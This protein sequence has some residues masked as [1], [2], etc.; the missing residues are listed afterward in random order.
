MITIL[1]G[2]RFE[3]TGLGL[4]GGDVGAAEG[5]KS[6]RKD[7]RS[8]KAIL[9]GLVGWRTTVVD[10]DYFRMRKRL[11]ESSVHR[12]NWLQLVR[13]GVVAQRMAGVLRRP[14]LRV[15]NTQVQE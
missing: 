2:F 3:D 10:D 13:G 4:R 5:S 1:S 11:A 12:G 8:P 7:R 6:A 15:S 14:A 9:S